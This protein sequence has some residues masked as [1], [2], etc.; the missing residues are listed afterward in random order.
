MQIYSCM[1]KAIENVNM[2]VLV[3]KVPKLIDQKRKHL[4]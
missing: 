4:E 2:K 3:N 1:R